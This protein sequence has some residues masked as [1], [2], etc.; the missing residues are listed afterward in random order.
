MHLVD[1]IF[2]LSSGRVT[3]FEQSGLA[4]E[5]LSRLGTTIADGYSSNSLQKLP[6]VTLL[7]PSFYHE[8]LKP[9]LAEWAYL[10]L[11]KNHLHGID[12]AEAIEYILEG[13]V[14]RSD[15]LLKVNL[16][17]AAVTR[18]EVD[19]GEKPAEPPLTKG[20]IR[21]LKKEASPSSSSIVGDLEDDDTFDALELPPPPTSRPNLIREKT[22][23]TATDN[24][25][26]NSTLLREKKCLEAARLAA[27]TQRG[28]IAEI[29]A[30]EAGL[31]SHMKTTQARQLELA[32]ESVQLAKEIEKL[33]AP[34]DDSL[35]NSTVVWVSLAFATGSA[36]GGGDGE[37]DSG[38]EEEDA[39]SSSKNGK[40][41]ATSVHSVLTVLEDIGLTVK[42]CGDPYEA[43]DRCRELQVNK[44]LRA[45]VYG[46]G[47][48]S[49]GCGPS[50]SKNHRND[51]SCI[52]CGERFG[53]P[54]HKNHIC[55]TGSHQGQRGSWKKDGSSSSK[56][57]DLSMT[58]D[59]F[60]SILTDEECAFAKQH[61][62][63][64]PSNRC[65]LYGGNSAVKQDL[66]QD[67]WGLGV[68]VRDTPGDI[69]NWIDG[70]AA[71]KDDDDADEV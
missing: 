50:C 47:E 11:Q 51:G 69:N 60:F 71:W 35:D 37:Y 36:G 61:G 26:S 55:Q 14:A 5:I 25:N 19:L 64:L 44:Q 15:L 58:A 18:C 16:I 39:N 32:K 24:L 10:W 29:F 52:I 41:G 54:H 21:A 34:R 8:K 43:I 27:E 67:L 57:R 66:R 12:R 6:H 70:I 33:E 1:A 48:A 17:D 38:E 65:A 3:T 31:E 59:E 45:V 42:R 22:L 4:L 53:R 2:F 63:S 20:H 9:I 68:C 28:L 49:Q 40:N 56:K 23:D 62:S 30:V 13:A 46:G 7:N